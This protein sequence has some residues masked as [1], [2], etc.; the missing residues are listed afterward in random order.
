MQISQPQSPGSRVKINRPPKVRSNFCPALSEP[1]K[2]TV[3]G[4]PKTSC[5]LSCVTVL[6]SNNKPYI[7]AVMEN[8]LMNG[9]QRV[10]GAQQRICPRIDILQ[11]GRPVPHFSRW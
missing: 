3:A 4:S 5:K 1:P 9:F 2:P 11:T 8:I 7:A 6:E 10:I